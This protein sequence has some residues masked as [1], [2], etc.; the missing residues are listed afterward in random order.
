MWRQYRNIEPEEFIVV[1]V[2]TAA[3]G[4]DYCA[5]QFISVTKRDVPI[6]YHAKEL[7]SEMTP[8]INRKL[9]DIYTE[10]GVKPTIAYE[11]NNGGVFELERLS[12]LNNAGMFNIY[13]T[14]QNTGTIRGMQMSPK[15]GWNT[16]SSTRPV[17]LGDLKE[18]IDN[19]L[20][21]FY[22]RPTLNELLSFVIVQSTY[23]WK[24]QAENG[25]HDD[26]VMALAIAWQLYQTERA[27]NTPKF[28]TVKPKPKEP[29]YK[30]G[31]L[32]FNEQL[33]YNLDME[34]ALKET[35]KAQG[36]DWRYQ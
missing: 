35:T 29:E 17:M 20:L 13:Q 2:D 16:D 3:G 11:R 34:K 1:G 4:N 28:R 6:V 19:K 7:A 23:S 36:K 22:D 9:I 33:Q 18:A 32:V 21:L 14:K 24:A 27:F 12:R 31:Y 26:L 25:M 8:Q 30:E 15:L 5:A 10:T